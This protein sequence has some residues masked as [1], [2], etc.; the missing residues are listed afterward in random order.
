MYN[1]RD[2]YYE[3]VLDEDA[4]NVENDDDFGSVLDDFRGLS[5]S[6]SDW[7]VETLYGQIKKGNIELSPGFQRREVWDL[8]KKTR[9]IESL[10]LSIP[11][12]Q[13][14]IA[15]KKDN[16]GRYIVLDGKQ[17][18]LCIEA[19]Y[20][21]DFV[22]KKPD[23]LKDLA[24]KGY[25]SLDEAQ[26]NALDNAT[27]RAVRLGGWKKD[28]VLYTIFNRLNT[29]SV[30]L[31]TQELRSALYAGPFTA[32]AAE[33]TTKDLELALLFNASASKADFR[34]RDVELLT[35]YCG[36]AHK[37]EFYAGNLKDFLDK[38]TIWLN[39]LESPSRYESYAREA[40]AAISVYK[41][42]Y[43]EV[44]EELDAGSLP[45]FTL[46]QDDKRP[47]FNR[48][49]FDALCYPSQDVGVRAQISRQKREVATAMIGILRH[50]S[51]I[52][53]CS[54]STKT[55]ASLVR[56]VSMWADALSSVLGMPVKTLSLGDDSHVQEQHTVC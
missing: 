49:V 36:I 54:L 48:A 30:Q 5:L 52:E 53:V 2:E 33:Y 13:I 20:N 11:V 34:M 22:L 51:F 3:P 31:N 4:A 38:T 46:I 23:L 6:S 43:A 40:V 50:P 9:F 12:P 7:T 35:R 25:G 17:R 10:L 41:D 26:R 16:K 47:K 21:G 27:M 24:G 28:V 14:V 18:L 37:P 8:G 29:G 45:T 42:V 15:D 56:R 1:D 44:A 32:F 19:F 55:P 39:G